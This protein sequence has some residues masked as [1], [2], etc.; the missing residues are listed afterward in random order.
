MRK[1]SFPTSRYKLR[2]AANKIRKLAGVSDDEPFPVVKFLETILLAEGW[3]F[4]IVPD[5]EMPEKYAET[6][7]N[8]KNSVFVK[9]YTKMPLKTTLGIVLP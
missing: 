8:E 9:V 2:M 3:Q 7:P 5:D 4:D 6:I 1:E